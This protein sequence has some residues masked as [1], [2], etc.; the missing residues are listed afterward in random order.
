MYIKTM[1]N[2]NKNIPTQAELEDFM[3]D[4]ENK[5]AQH[6]V[7]LAE[8]DSKCDVCFGTGKSKNTTSHTHGRNCLACDGSGLR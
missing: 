5:H 4:F 6:L 2:A 1:N 7:E 3:A 8:G